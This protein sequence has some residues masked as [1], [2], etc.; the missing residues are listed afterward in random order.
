MNRKIEKNALGQKCLNFLQEQ[1]ITLQKEVPQY[2][3]FLAIN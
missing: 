2:P 1:N 3:Q